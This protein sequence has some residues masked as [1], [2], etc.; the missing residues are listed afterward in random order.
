MALR[1]GTPGKG[2]CVKPDS[3]SYT[4]VHHGLKNTFG[5]WL[6]GDPYWALAHEHTKATPGTKPCL[7]WLTDG[8]VPCPRCRPQVRPVWIGWVP[9]YREIDHK[10][11]MV[12]VHESVMD[13]LAGLGYPTHVLVGRVDENSSVFVKRSD[14]AVSFAT[15]N[16]QRKCAVDITADLLTMW[17]IPA[18]ER[19]LL[20]QRRPAAGPALKS[21]GEP[22]SAMTAA[23]AERYGDQGGAAK[24]ADDEYR[25]VQNRVMEHM[26]NVDAQKNGKHK[27]K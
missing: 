14:N 7:E 26:G 19:W 6:A 23:A 4:P 13:L 9:L 11:I 17:G 21:T 18:L 25:A 16:Q 27:P 22:F 8:A 10:P 20:D 15:G 3:F 5:A 2:V 24:L 12:I 1:K